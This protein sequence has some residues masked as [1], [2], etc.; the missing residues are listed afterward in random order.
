MQA[1]GVGGGRV[2]VFAGG[3]FVCQLCEPRPARWRFAVVNVK[4]AR[5]AGVVGGALRFGEVGFYAAA[6]Q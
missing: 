1:G 6:A 5:R 2:G 3:E 4:A